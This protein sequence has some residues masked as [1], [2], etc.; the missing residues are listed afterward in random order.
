M[1]FTTTIL[2][3]FIDRSIL[4]LFRSQ[5]CIK[6]FFVFTIHIDSHGKK[7]RQVKVTFVVYLQKIPALFA[8][9]LEWL[10]PVYSCEVLIESDKWIQRRYF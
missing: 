4:R 3:V 10:I 6:C 7:L 2:F 9:C 5:I 1:H 8:M